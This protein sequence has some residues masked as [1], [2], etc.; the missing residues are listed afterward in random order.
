MKVSKG[1][2]CLL[3]LLTVCAIL[4]LLLLTCYREYW[5]FWQS[6]EMY[7]FLSKEYPHWFRDYI[8]NYYDATL[9][10][11]V[12]V[13][14][15]WLCLWGQRREATCRASVGLV[16]MTLLFGLTIGVLCSNN[17]IQFLDSGQLHGKTHLPTRD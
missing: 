6:P 9:L 3:S 2:F 14:L 4:W 8:R 13:Y 17:L 7:R 1:Q 12:F 16:S 10:F 11:T 15:G 5:G